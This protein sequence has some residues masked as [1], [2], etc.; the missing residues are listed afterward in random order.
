MQRD[1]PISPSKPQKIVRYLL[2]ICLLIMLLP[3]MGLFIPRK[4]Y[5]EPQ[6]SC[7]YK[8][9]VA[10]FGYHSKLLV[11]VRNAIFNWRDY[12]SFD[13][14]YR[15]LGFGWGER[16]WYINPPTQLDRK[17]F[18][19]IRA[20]LFPNPSV[21]RVQRYYSLPQHEEIEC[22]GVSRANYLNLVEFIQ[23]S[24]QKDAS[25][26]TVLV[27]DRPAW[28]ATFYEANGTYWLLNNSNHWTAQGLKSAGLNTPLWPG[29]SAAIMGVLKDH[30]QS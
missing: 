18:D 26:K 17:L 29:H 16:A 5:D 22:M 2:S 14:N 21:M 7:E 10:K 28:N 19:G 24:F 27:A 6:A 1:R 8:V 4:W 15:Y 23:A 11:P 30:C 9:C 13:S 12:F 25:G 3:V 20:L